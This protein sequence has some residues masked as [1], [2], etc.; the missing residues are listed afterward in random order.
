MELHDCKN[1]GNEKQTWCQILV[2][3]DFCSLLATAVRSDPRQEKMAERESKQG[4]G[5]THAQNKKKPSSQTE[6]AKQACRIRLKSD[7]P[8]GT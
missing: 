8:H 2:L 3:A 7:A 4:G 5:D 1:R 6:A